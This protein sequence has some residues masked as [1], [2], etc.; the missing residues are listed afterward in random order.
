MKAESLDELPAS[1]LSACLASCGG[2]DHKTREV[3]R[4]LFVELDRP[5]S[6]ASAKLMAQ[7]Y[8]KLEESLHDR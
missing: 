4:H 7:L 1:I 8:E 6:P 3:I 5:R 2:N